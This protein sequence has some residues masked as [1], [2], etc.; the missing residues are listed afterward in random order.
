[1][2]GDVALEV[3]ESRRDVAVVLVS[4]ID[5]IPQYNHVLVVGPQA[6]NA[7]DRTDNRQDQEVPRFDETNF[8]PHMVKLSFIHRVYDYIA[9][10]LNL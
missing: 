7:D 8:S 4:S 3:L 5:G 2:G 10:R 1:M 6:H 9:S